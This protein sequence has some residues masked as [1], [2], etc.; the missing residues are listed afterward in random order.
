MFYIDQITFLTNGWMVDIE[1][2]GVIGR[3]IKFRS[4][5]VQ[6]MYCYYYHHN[7]SS[8]GARDQHGMCL[9]ANTFNA[10]DGM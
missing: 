8:S 2:P 6:H 4:K 1:C 3:D 9:R 10:L 7:N 5:I